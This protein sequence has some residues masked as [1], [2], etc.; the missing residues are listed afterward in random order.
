MMC[1][2]GKDVL[3]VALAYGSAMAVLGIGLWLCEC[4]KEWLYWRRGGW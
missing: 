1:V 4:V 3:V 2:D